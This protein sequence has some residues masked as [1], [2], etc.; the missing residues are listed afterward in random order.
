VSDSPNKTIH[1]NAVAPFYAEI[2]VLPINV[3]GWW[4]PTS[5]TAAKYEVYKPGSTVAEWW[6]GVSVFATS[7]AGAVL[8]AALVAGNVDVLGHYAVRAWVLSAGT[9]IPS[10]FE[11]IQVIV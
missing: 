8:R 11:K 10:Q 3:A 4:D 2:T 5:V 7:T 6:L 1:Q 9:W